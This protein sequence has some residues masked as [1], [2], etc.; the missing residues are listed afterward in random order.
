[1]A[2]EVVLTDK[3]PRALGAYSQGI[4]A[5]GFVFVAMQGPSD[6][7]TGAL[8]GESIQEQTA[9]CL[10]NVEAILVAAGSSLEKVVSA[11]F[12]LWEMSDFAGMNEEWGRWFPR[13]PP[14]RLAAGVPI[15]PPGVKV[16]VA[17]IA[18]A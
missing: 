7:V 11:T 10:R 18:E 4:K 8:R 5:G 15:R 1:M 13:D 2:K 14:V 17:A 9:Q 12:V 3:A 6:P 16:V